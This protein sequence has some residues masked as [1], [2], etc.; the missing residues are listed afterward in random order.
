MLAGKTNNKAI[1][2]YKKYSANNNLKNKSYAFKISN[3]ALI[4][5]QSKFQ[6]QWAVKYHLEIPKFYSFYPYSFYSTE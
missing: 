5:N 4:N 3:T 2:A 6:V 1:I